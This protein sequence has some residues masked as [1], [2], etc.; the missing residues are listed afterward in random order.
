LLAPLVFDR[1]LELSLLCIGGALLR[2]R[3]DFTDEKKR[4]TGLQLAASA[5]LREV[6]FPVAGIALAL[7]LA[8]RIDGEHGATALLLLSLV[9]IFIVVFTIFSAGRPLR[10][11]LCVAAIALF[12][13]QFGN[14]ASANIVRRDRTFFGTH[15]I[16]HD[17]ERG[18]LTFLHGN[19]IHG[20]RNT[21]PGSGRERQT[22]YHAGTGFGRLY[23]A[24]GAANQTPKRIGA[25]GLGVGEIACYRREGQH[26]TF[27]EIDPAVV[28]IATSGKWFTYLPR[29][30]PNARIVLGDGR[31]TLAREP[32]GAFDLLVLDAFASDS[33]PTHL[34]T[35]E[36]FRLYLDK[37]APGGFILVHISN[38]YLDLEPVI[39]GLAAD[40]KLAARLFDTDKATLEKDNPYRFKSSWVALARDEAG[41]KALTEAYDKS[42]P[43]AWGH[44]RALKAQ[45]G[46]RLWTDDYSTIITL[47]R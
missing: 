41:L 42:A 9:A 40:A 1:V 21:A 44:W 12:G 8:P 7:M 34:V 11:G 15:V 22:Y 45:P 18:Y 47:M 31:L 3:T 39:A 35:R 37:L 32:K 29:C 5:I 43:S 38:R 6:S 27:F 30:A 16:K 26:W 25:V 4:E 13:M 20:A 17:A 24:L 33:I 10:F 36:A 14:A 2:P 19:T 28:R 46:L 23:A